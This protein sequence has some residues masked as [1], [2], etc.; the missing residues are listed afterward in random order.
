MESPQ[1]AQDINRA[2]SVVYPLSRRPLDIPVVRPDYNTA[3]PK[4]GVS[5]CQ[6]SSDG[7]YLCTFDGTSLELGYIYIRR[8]SNV[9][10]VYIDSMPTALWLWDVLQMS[11]RLVV[12]HQ[13]V[14]RQIT[15]NP[16]DPDTLATSCGSNHVLLIKRQPPHS[17]N[18]SI[19]A[20]EYKEPEPRLSASA[21]TTLLHAA[22]FD[23]RKLIWSQN[24][25]SLLIASKTMF[26]LATVSD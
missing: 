1:N 8:T 25:K 19:K 23:V 10:M 24:G 16:Q 21:Y 22:N 20:C 3:N 26:C 12:I 9:K 15:W 6:F 14:I 17:K 2:L 7:H 18:L 11:C 5:V 13:Q 4:V